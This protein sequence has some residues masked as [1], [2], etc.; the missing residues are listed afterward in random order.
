MWFHLFG[1]EFKFRAKISWSKCHARS[2]LAVRC[3]SMRS[4]IPFISC[5]ICGW[6]WGMWNSSFFSLFFFLFCPLIVPSVSGIICACGL[7]HDRMTKWWNK[8]LILFEYS[9][10]HRNPNRNMNPFEDQCIWHWPGTFYNLS[11][12]F[13]Q[14]AVSFQSFS[15]D[16]KILFK[17]NGVQFKK[18]T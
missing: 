12:H 7:V 1:L 10:N 11:D 15:S 14:I 16:K 2:S 17:K 13:N 3:D 4:R 5:V 18:S 8:C 6:R 9:S